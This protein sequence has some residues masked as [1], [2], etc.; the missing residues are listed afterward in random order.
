MV[1]ISNLNDSL[2]CDTYPDDIIRGKSIGFRTRQH[3]FLI[4]DACML[5]RTLIASD[6]FGGDVI[7]VTYMTQ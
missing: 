4:D 5:T 2:I 3:R 6:H 1:M 7:K